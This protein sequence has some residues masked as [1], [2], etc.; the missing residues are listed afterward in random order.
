MALVSEGV[1][2]R[3]TLGGSDMEWRGGRQDMVEEMEL[4]T[5]LSKS[6]KGMRSL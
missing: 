6:H 5:V 4:Q 2:E 3:F 1:G